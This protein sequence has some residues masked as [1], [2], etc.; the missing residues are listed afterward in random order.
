MKKYLP[1]I[2]F[3]LFNNILIQT[4]Y[5][6][7]SISQAQSIFI[8]N[9][10]RMIEWP[11]DRSSGSFTIGVYG[12]SDMFSE[13]KSYTSG[14]NVGNQS[15]LIKKLNSV[16]EMEGLHILFVAFGKTKEMAEILKKIGDNSTMIICEKNGSLEQGATINFVVIEDK[17][18]YEV[19]T[20]T[21]KKIGLKFNA[22]LETM[23]ISKH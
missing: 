9:F 17:L 12:S 19:K 15:I 21:A 8:Y 22:Y 23:S 5:S 14:K 1:V 16:D 3:V 6:Q 7:A 2:L 4:T 13:L 10:T 11:A 18:R 20:A